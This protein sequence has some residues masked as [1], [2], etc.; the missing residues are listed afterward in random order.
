MAFCSPEEWVR[1]HCINY[2][3]HTKGYPSSHVSVE[4]QIDVYGLKKV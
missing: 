3:V 1:V 4:H 2:I